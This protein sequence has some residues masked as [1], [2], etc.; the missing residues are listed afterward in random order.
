MNVLIPL[1]GSGSRFSKVGFQTPKPKIL[2]NDVPMI[3]LAVDSLNIDGQ[4]IFI[5]QRDQNLRSLLEQIKPNCIIIEID[6]ITEGAAQ[7]CLLAKQY[8][9]NDF[10]L[11]VSNC[12]QYLDWD[13]SRFLE[14]VGSSNEI[15][16]CVV[17]YETN[18]VANSYVQL[19]EQ[20]YAVRLAE[21]ELISTSGLIGVHYWSKGS[22]FVSSA[23]AIIRDNI[24]A[25][26]EFYVS[27]TY[28]VLIKQ[29]KKIIQHKLSEN[30]K[31]HSLGTPE[32]MFTFT[33]SGVQKYNLSDYTR[34]WFI[35]NFEPTVLKQSQF[36]VGVLSHKKDEVWAVHYHSV[37]KEINV[38][39]EG[40]MK[41][42][43]LDVNVGDI[44]VFEPFVIAVPT[45]L[46]DC[47]I[48]CIKTP[49]CPGEKVL[50]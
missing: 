17:T 3:K 39:L 29:G 19:D 21:K 47:K 16:G 33:G 20:G 30:E 5:C 42:N 28:N 35:G 34:G 15:D 14:T 27:L 26:N 23:E 8:I 6:Y 46:T 38:L 40:R 49:S 2:I 48:L 13:S 44:F 50:V 36:E 18:N 43:G 10:P 12:D 31:Y 7:T 25:K 37:S 32:D 1:A 45:F 24:R 11:V 9:D 22:D 4:Y 41:V